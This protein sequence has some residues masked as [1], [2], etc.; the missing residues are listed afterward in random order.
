MQHVPFGVCLFSL[1]ILRS[2]FTHVVACVRISFLVKLLTSYW[3]L[4]IMLLWTWVYR[5]LFEPLL[6]L[7]WGRARSGISGLYGNFLF[8]F[9]GKNTFP[10]WLHCFTFLQQVIRFFLAHTILPRPI[11]QNMVFVVDWFSSVKV[12]LH[13]GRVEGGIGLHI[14][15]TAKGSRNVEKEGKNKML[16][17]WHN[18]CRE[19]KPTFQRI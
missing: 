9:W 17:L 6:S 10:Q 2:R 1:S 5:F 18:K 15:I 14:Y 13:W 7:L 8:N 12:F 3:L 19:E 4:W 16:K 11:S